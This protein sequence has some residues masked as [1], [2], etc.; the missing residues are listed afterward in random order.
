[1]L[2]IAY[3]N[4]GVE[5]EHMKNLDDALHWY[6]KAYQTLEEHGSVDEKLYKQFK[7]AH[8]KAQDVPSFVQF[9]LRS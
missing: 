9:Y 5:E 6:E 8:A 3:H 2:A 1:M 7:A 4:M